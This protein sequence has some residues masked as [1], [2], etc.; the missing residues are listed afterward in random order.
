VR[1]LIPHTAGG[2]FFATSYIGTLH[3][4]IFQSGITKRRFSFSCLTE[5]RENRQLTF[6]R[7]SFSTAC[8]ATGVIWLILYISNALA[9]VLAKEYV[10]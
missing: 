1:A 4:D 9:V 7:M 3:A 6:Q 2:F 10:L 8:G 5:K